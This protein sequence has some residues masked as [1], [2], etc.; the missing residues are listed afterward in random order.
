MHY[1]LRTQR[2]KTILQILPHEKSWGPNYLRSALS[3]SWINQDD[4]RYNLRLAYHMTK[5]NARGGDILFSGQL[6]STNLLGIS[7]HQ[8]LSSNSNWFVNSRASV[9]DY[10]IHLYQENKREAEFRNFNT[11]VQAGIGYEFERYGIAQVGMRIQQQRANLNIGSTNQ[12]PR[13]LEATSSEVFF[14]ADFDRMNRL[15]FPTSGWK[16]R[17]EYT[18]AKEYEKVKT[19]MS[20]A[21]SLGDYVL[22]SR[23]AY[24]GA[25]KGSLPFYDAAQVGGPNNIWGLA[26]QQILGDGFRY[27]GVGFERVVSKMPLGLRGDLRLGLMLEGA[28]LKTRYTENQDSGLIK[29]VGLY[30]GGETPVGVVYL[31]VAKASNNKPRVYLFIGTP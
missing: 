2:D 5:L 15:Y 20:F 22:N 16:S 10:K 18:K 7:W 30:F 25:T 9:S 8:P 6:G 1:Q 29:S 13:K 11:G 21:Y 26:P 23:L 3:V 19:E 28:K 17:L 27:G 24:V 14:L 31:G 4:A 12:F